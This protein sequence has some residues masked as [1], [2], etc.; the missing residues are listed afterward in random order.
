MYTLDYAQELIKQYLH[1]EFEDIE[2]DITFDNLE[3]ISL[4]FTTWE[5]KDTKHEYEVTATVDLVHFCMK[6]YIDN[7]C[8]RTKSYSSL[9]DFINEELNVLDFNDLTN[10]DWYCKKHGIKLVD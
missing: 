5:E 4:A 9:V 10:I 2:D 8:V 1:E 7:K 3:E 6:Q